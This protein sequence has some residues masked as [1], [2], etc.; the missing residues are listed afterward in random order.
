MELTQESFRSWLL[1]KDKHEII[2]ERRDSCKCPLANWIN[3]SGKYERK[4]SITSQS[5]YVS[6]THS[7][8]TEKWMKSFIRYTDIP[9]SF[10]LCNAEEALFTLTKIENNL[11]Q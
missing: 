9:I 7:R 4:I 10:P 8:P 1:T 3:S 11:T 5:I 2:G 6:T